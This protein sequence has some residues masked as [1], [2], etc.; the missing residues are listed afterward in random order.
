MRI[1]EARAECERY[2]AYLA[3][4]EIKSRALQKLASDRRAGRCDDAEKDR[5]MAEI[6]G[7]SPRVYDG[8]E[9]AKAI[10]ILLAVTTPP[11]ESGN[12]G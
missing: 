11:R 5:R 10:R 2:L 4:E 7:P 1:E 3:R 12:G 8:A 6:M 9:L